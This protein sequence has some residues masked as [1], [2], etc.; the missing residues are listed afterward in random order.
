MALGE[1]SWLTLLELLQLLLSASWKHI[2][3]HSKG[4]LQPRRCLGTTPLAS[5]LLFKAVKVTALP[6]SG[7]WSGPLL[8]LTQ[9]VWQCAEKEKRR[10]GKVNWCA[11]FCLNHP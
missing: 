11:G 3:Y 6:K 8:E 10:D 9:W 1:G 5:P 4:T 7:P 2:P